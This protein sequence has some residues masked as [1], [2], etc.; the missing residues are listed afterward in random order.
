MYLFSMTFLVAEISMKCRSTNIIFDSTFLVS[1]VFFFAFFFIFEQLHPL[2]D[3]LRSQAPHG[4]AAEEL[5]LSQGISHEGSDAGIDA[6][7][8][9]LAGGLPSRP[10][11]GGGVLRPIVLGCRLE[12]VV[13]GP[14]SPIPIPSRSQA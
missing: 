6:H 1:F 7:G 3:R 14:P 9:F 2:A 4:S 10:T 5:P 8:P 11:M 12:E 13:P